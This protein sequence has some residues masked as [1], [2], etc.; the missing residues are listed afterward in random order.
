[1]CDAATIGKLADTPLTELLESIG[2]SAPVPGAGPAAAFV[3][4]LA[5]ALVEMVSAVSLRQEEPAE[6]AA[7]ETRRARCAELR[8][9]APELAEEDMAAYADV[10]AARRV[11]SEP[12]GAERLHDALAAA[13]DPPL[14]IAEAAAEVTRLAAEAFAAA[15]GAVR[16]EAATAALLAEAVV[17]AAATI[18]ELN[19]AGS[20]ADSRRARARDLAAAARG[21]RE[22][23]G[24]R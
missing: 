4:A 15:R 7:L 3:C 20:P 17:R 11:R 12:G 14:A 13:A 6:H 16:G 22:L 21:D 24:A 23:T 8:A 2:S 19:L 10:L 5:A 18:V 1:L 9:A